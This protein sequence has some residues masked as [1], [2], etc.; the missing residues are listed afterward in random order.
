[1]AFLQ[2]PKQLRLCSLCGLYPVLP[3]AKFGKSCLCAGCLDDA[4]LRS[5]LEQ[6]IITHDLAQNFTFELPIMAACYY[7]HPVNE[8]LIAYKYRGDLRLTDVLAQ[9]MLTLPKPSKRSVLVPMPSSKARLNERGFDHIDRLCKQLAKAWGL[10]IWRGV[11]RVGESTHQKGASR[12]NRL[13]NMEGQF[14][15]THS[16]PLGNHLLLIDDVLTT[17]ASLNALADCI[18]PDVSER[19]KNTISAF[20]LAH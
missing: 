7:R 16:P 12:A 8:A 15:R 13:R 18:L 4:P 14:V 20:V 9:Y 2:L 6:A 17:G 19:S 3:A 11:K 10:P 1:M 5:T